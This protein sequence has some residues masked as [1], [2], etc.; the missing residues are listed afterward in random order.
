MSDSIVILDAWT[1]NPG[2]LSWSGLEALAPLRA[3]DRTAPSEIVSRVG[4]ATIVLTNKTMLNAE[5][6][7]AL[8]KVKYIGVLATG[9]NVVDL[10]AA[11]AR[12]VVV[13]NV[14]AYGSASV[15]QTVFAL[16]LELTHRVGHHAAAVRE[17]RWS[18]CPDF[19]FWDFPLIE[20]AGRTFGIV[21]YGRIGRSVARIAQG[22]GMKVLATRRDEEPGREG[23]VE[24]VA[25]EILFREADVLSLHCPLTPET[26]GLVDARRLAWMK[27]TAFLI[28]TGRGALVVEQDLAS[29]LSAG[30]LAGAGLDVLAVEPPPP[31]NPLLS[32]KNCLVTPHLGWA[33]REARAR[34]IEVAAG[35]V[36][37]F[38]A[39]TPRNIV[40]QD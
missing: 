40:G 29:A 24:F 5:T 16:L 15:A 1:A 39:G 8:P 32:A 17:G 7:A 31:D 19:S 14:P 27:P 30:R 34:L 6:I 2:D 4:D 36:R 9:V 23:D 10:A 21:G 35:N 3:F 22:F 37:A 11:K 33:T 18:R 28:N 20:L 12:G 25:R 38:L 26:R 13:T